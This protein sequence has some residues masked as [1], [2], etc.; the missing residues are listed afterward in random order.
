MRPLLQFLNDQPKPDLELT[1]EREQGQ[2]PL[3]L[4]IGNFIAQETHRLT[5]LESDQLGKRTLGHQPQPRRIDGHTRR[6]SQQINRHFLFLNTIEDSLDVHPVPF[7]LVD[8]CSTP[9]S[10]Q[11]N[12]RM[13]TSYLKNLKKLASLLPIRYSI[14]HKFS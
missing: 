5:V 12:N 6:I 7:L 13:H 11:K 8:G 9:P 1:G 2:Q 10:S 4:E 3:Y 14:T